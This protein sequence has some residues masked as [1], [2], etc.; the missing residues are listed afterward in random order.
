MHREKGAG[1]DTDNVLKL[2]EA[3]WVIVAREAIRGPFSAPTKVSCWLTFPGKGRT[4]EFNPESIQPPDLEKVL[5]LSNDV[6]SRAS[7]QNLDSAL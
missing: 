2:G 7:K 3:N 6:A 5:Q 1:L 4:R